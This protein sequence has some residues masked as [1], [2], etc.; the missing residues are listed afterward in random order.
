MRR[1]SQ[2]VLK[3]IPEWDVSMLPTASIARCSAEVMLVTDIPKFTSLAVIPYAC[4]NTANKGLIDI[5]STKHIIYWH[6]IV[7]VLE[8]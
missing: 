8:Q 5:R 7:F 3:Q 6:A 4:A 1:S 2:G